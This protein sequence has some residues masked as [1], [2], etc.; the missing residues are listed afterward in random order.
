MRRPG[1]GRR[2]PAS[3]SGRMILLAL[4]A[5]F[6]LL[7]PLLPPPAL[8]AANHAGVVV[9]QGDGSM[10]Y[11]YVAFTEERLNGLEVLRRSGIPLVTAGFGGLGEAVCSM[12]GTGCSLAECQRT[13]CQSGGDAPYWRYFR[14][15]ELGVWEPLALGASSTAVRDGDIDGWSWTTGDAA[16][17]A[18][19]LPE[20][21]ALAGFSASAAP[22]ER[23]TVAVW[24]RS[25]GETASEPGSGRA[26]YVGAG[27]LLAFIG[28]GALAAALRRRG[29]PDAELEAA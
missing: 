2:D 14:Q 1:P 25:G 29:D 8:A 6:A 23:G 17:P 24:R 4:A 9:R 18:M 15:E 19:T 16:L 3:R 28:G 26:G 13:L 22:D 27:I 21:A 5:A 7:L 10:L 11:G 12:D 20:L